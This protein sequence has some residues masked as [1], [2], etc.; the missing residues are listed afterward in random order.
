MQWVSPGLRE[1]GWVLG[2]TVLLTKNKNDESVRVCCLITKF[3]V[4]RE[5]SEIYEIS[6]LLS[7]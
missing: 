3:T 6:D 2:D 1:C 5:I 7:I 4:P